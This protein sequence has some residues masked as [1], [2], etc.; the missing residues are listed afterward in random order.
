MESKRYH[1][2]SLAFGAL[3][4]T[5]IRTLE[6]IV[7]YLRKKTENAQNPLTKCIFCMVSCCL[8]C[9]ECIFNRINKNGFIFIS[10]Y[11]TPFCYSSYCALQLVLENLGKT[12]AMTG[13]SRYT[14]QFGRFVISLL[15]TAIGLLIMKYN[16]YYINNLESYL[17]PCIIIFIISY[18][19][20]ALFMMVFDVAVQTI[21]LCFLVDEQ[22]NN[23]IPKFATD[24]IKNII[25]AAASISSKR[26]TMSTIGSSKDSG[27]IQTYA[28][29]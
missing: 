14:E 12:F 2:G 26:S 17:F 7:L 20:S 9:C 13:I 16:I 27:N 22:V 24:G 28:A 23:G 10:I 3:I 21:F 19:I 8:K 4:I 5:I 25:G 15:N 18:I 6:G 29:I 1:L 11:G